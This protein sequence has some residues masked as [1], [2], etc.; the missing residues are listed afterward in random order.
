MRAL[1]IIHDAI[2][3]DVTNLL[4]SSFKDFHAKGMDYICLKR[5]PNHTVKVYILDGDASKL[6]EVVNPHDHRY[7]F[8]TTVLKGKMLDKRFI[9]GYGGDVYEAF[10]YMTPLNGGNGFTWRGEETLMEV[11]LNF[12]DKGESLYTRATQ[13]HTIAMREDQTIIMLDQYKDTVPVYAPTSTWVRKGEPKPDTSGLYTRF[14][15]GEF[16]DKL[17]W[18]ASVLA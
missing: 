8:R 17:V 15:E 4:E 18:L 5:T 14:T 1:D 10:D 11:G 9:H 13:L 6:P 7:G 16:I 12:L 3:G 2:K